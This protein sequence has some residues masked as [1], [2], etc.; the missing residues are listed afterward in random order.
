MDEPVS[1]RSVVPGSGWPGD[2][3]TLATPVAESAA[4]VQALRASAPDLDELVARQSVCRAC[5]RLVAWREEVATVRRKSFIDEVYWGRP[6]PGW[7][8]PAPAIIILGL[9]PA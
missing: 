3:A 6:I 2:P 8:D 5:P 7:G 4:D 9:A 1:G